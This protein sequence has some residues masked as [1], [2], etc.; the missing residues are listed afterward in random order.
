MPLNEYVQSVVTKAT[1]RNLTE[2]DVRS[3]GYDLI[4]ELAG[5]DDPPPQDFIW[6]QVRQQAADAMAAAI[7]EARRAEQKASLESLLSNE[8]IT[9][10]HPTI[11]GLTVKDAPEGPGFLL[12]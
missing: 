7:A 1:K 4:L 11:E 5:V 12:E 8:M 9:A 3:A 2:A 10:L 6:Y